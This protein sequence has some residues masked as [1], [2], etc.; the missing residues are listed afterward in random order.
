[1]TRRKDARQELGEETPSRGTGGE[2]P[3]GGIQSGSLG[4]QWGGRVAAADR[5][6]GR[7]VGG[8]RSYKVL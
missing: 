3:R 6:G 4:K 1:M 2:G 5:A 8:V 7:V